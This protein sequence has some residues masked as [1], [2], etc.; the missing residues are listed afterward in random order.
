VLVV[1]TRFT[2]MLV[3]DAVELRALVMIVPCA[4]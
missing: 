2:V 3:T 1:G 4:Y